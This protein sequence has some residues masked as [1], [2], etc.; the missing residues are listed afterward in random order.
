MRSDAMAESDRASG[1]GL[2]ACLETRSARCEMGCRKPTEGSIE[3]GLADVR[4]TDQQRL[5]PV[6]AKPNKGTS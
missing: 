6:G 3:M 4:A 2:F 1:T 5:S